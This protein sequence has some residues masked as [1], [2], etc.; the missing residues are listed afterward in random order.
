MYHVFQSKDKNCF[1]P[2]A[3]VHLAG[4]KKNAICKPMSVPVLKQAALKLNKSTLN[5][6]VMGMAAVAIKKYMISHGET[7]KK[8]IN[9]II[10]FSLR[11]IPKQKKDIMIANDFSALSF[12]L[13]LDT[14]LQK[15]VQGVK[16]ATR[17][18]KN[19]LYPWGMRALCEVAALVPGIVGQ[20]LGHW[21]FDKS[22]LAFSNVP[23]PKR[24]IK[25]GEGI[26]AV[27]FI[28]LVP[29]LGDLA[30]GM[31]GISMCDNLYFAIQSDLSYVKDPKEFKKYVEEAYEE[32]K[33]LV[34]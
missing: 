19:S 1:K 23:G 17:K 9:T 24:G 12:D 4:F 26:Y 28:A 27:G 3:D 30:F 5:D 21:I 25:F 13:S 14:D 11:T 32:V 34:E 8:K 33:K 29:G 18:L 16:S 7:D 6:V 22:T 10:P 2:K 20:L 15:A 31:T